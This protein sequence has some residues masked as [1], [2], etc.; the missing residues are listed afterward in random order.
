MYDQRRDRN[1]Q[2]AGFIFGTHFQ[3][4]FQIGLGHELVFGNRAGPITGAQ[5]MR[6]ALLVQVGQMRNGL[7]RQNAAQINRRVGLGIRLQHI[8]HVGQR[9]LGFVRS[10]DGFEALGDLRAGC[11][12]DI[13]DQLELG[14]IRR[15]FCRREQVGLTALRMPD[16]R[17]TLADLRLQ[18]ARGAHDVERV[19]CIGHALQ[20]RVKTGNAQALVVGGDDGIAVLDEVVE[21]VA[22]D[23]DVGMLRPLVGIA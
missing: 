22:D 12:C 16:D 11:E 23:L 18:C 1:L 8:Q 17:V 5:R 6:H 4:V 3:E 21:Q 13:A 14:H 9:Q 7:R 15:A 2:R 20:E 10:H 19:V